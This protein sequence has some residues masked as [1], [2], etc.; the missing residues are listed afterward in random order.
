MAKGA[1]RLSKESKLEDNGWLLQGDP[2]AGNAITFAKVLSRDPDKDPLA[3]TV[4]LRDVWRRS[5]GIFT[6]E[7]QS[8]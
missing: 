5:S 8:E 1:G 6:V 3:K 7:P 4:R 2:W